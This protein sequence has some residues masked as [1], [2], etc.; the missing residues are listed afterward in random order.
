MHGEG[1]GSPIPLNLHP[2]EEVQL[3]KITHVKFLLQFG[4]KL[5]QLSHVVCQDDEVIHIDDDNHNVGARL[6]NIQGAIRMTSNKAL[7]DKECM[8]VRS[9]RLFQAIE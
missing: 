3:P 7:L 6:H 5:H 1:A 2:Q 9:W 4:F 8:N